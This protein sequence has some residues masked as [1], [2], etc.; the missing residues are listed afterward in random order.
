[1]LFNEPIVHHILKW[2]VF[3]TNDSI[4]TTF[5]KFFRGIY[6]KCVVAHICTAVSFLF[7]LALPAE[8]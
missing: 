3:E 5:P 7:H 2:F 6:V 1:M 4:G 8:D